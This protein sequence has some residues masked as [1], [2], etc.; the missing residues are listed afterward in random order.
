MQ[1]VLKKSVLHGRIF[2]IIS[3]KNLFVPSRSKWISDHPG[4]RSLRKD[5]EILRIAC[6]DKYRR[7]CYTNCTSTR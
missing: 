3:V 6:I 2:C 1:A 5:K 4:G 7:Y